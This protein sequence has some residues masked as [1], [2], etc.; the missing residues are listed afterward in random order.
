MAREERH[1]CPVGALPRLLVLIG[2]GETAP[3]M[4][5]VHRALIGRLA[6][7]GVRHEEIR[8][9]VIDTTYGFQSNADAIS[10]DLIDFL[11]RRLGTAASV[12]SLRRADAD[13]LERETAL[14]R[15][16][17]AD[18][19]FSGPGSPTYAVRQWA[20]TEVPGLLAQKLDSGGAVVLASAAAMTAGRLMVPVYEIYKAGEDPRWLPGL[21]LLS[22]VE[23]PVAVITHWDNTEG[24]DH[25]TRYCFLGERRLRMLEEQMPDD[26]HILGIDEHTALLLDLDSGTARVEGRGRVTVRQR[27]REQAIAAG[28]EVSIEELG[29]RRPTPAVGRAAAVGGAPAIGRAPVSGESRK[30][31]ASD[32]EA[33]VRDILEAT[34]PDQRTGI[35]RLG[36][37]AGALTAE[38]DRL[39]PALISAL[40]QVRDA[41]RGGG[42][43]ATADDIRARLG[44]LGVELHDTADGRT[45][46]VIG[47]STR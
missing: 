25:D 42:D 37:L 12:A 3:R 18:F 19:V 1:T 10:A 45:D 9:A 17:D 22:V 40:V 31:R 44:A 13:L 30:A 16:R 41:A 15:I 6:G 11:G 5:R 47:L 32:V 35:V 36:E 39:V 7:E 28:Q 2:S 33:L 46:Y 21:D 43:W 23:L 4:A 29:G 34:G 38:R 14:A 8:A 24:A 20:G 27:G 26:S